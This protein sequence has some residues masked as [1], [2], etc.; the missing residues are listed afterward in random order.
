LQRT[1]QE[2]F[3][4][5]LRGAAWE[6][7]LTARPWGFRLEDIAMEVQLW[8]GQLDRNAPAAMGHHVAEAIPN[9]RAVFYEDEGHASL[10]AN[11]QEAILGALIPTNG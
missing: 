11:H 9:C 4:A 5:G 7:A 1:G 3:R 6:N 10:L 8:H 2:A